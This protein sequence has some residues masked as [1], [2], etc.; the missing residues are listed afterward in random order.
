[1]NFRLS[2]ST[3]PSR[4]RPWP[5]LTAPNIT[6]DFGSIKAIFTAPAPEGCRGSSLAA[7]LESLAQFSL[8]KGYYTAGSTQWAEV[9][10]ALAQGVPQ[11]EQGLNLH[12]KPIR[13]PFW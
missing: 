13:K 6:P 2:I 5:G 7:R 9:W 10:T 12:K 8:P 1:M 3:I 4:N 11:R